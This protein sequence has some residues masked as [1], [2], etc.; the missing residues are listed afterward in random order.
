MS[1]SLIVLIIL[2]VLAWGVFHAVGSYYGGAQL[3]PSLR[4]AAVVLGF[5]VAF[6]GFWLLMLRN[7]TTR[8]RDDAEARPSSSRD[9][10]P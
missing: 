7:R 6:L 9:A 3:A 4:R 1:R 2:G 5:T 8:L 10:R